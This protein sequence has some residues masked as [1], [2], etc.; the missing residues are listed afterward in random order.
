MNLKQKEKLIEIINKNYLSIDKLY[1]T[2]ESFIVEFKDR[3]LLNSY[4]FTEM[5]KINDKF[6]VCSINDKLQIEFSKL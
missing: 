6:F 3:E 5:M 4:V 1:E 2:E